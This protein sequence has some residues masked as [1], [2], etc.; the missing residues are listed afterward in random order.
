MSYRHPSSRVLSRISLEDRFN[1][2]V[3]LSGTSPEQLVPKGIFFLEILVLSS[4]TATIAD[5]KGTTI[6][7]GISS[8]TQENMPLRCDYGIT[9]TGA[10]LYAKG[11]VIEG[12][13]SE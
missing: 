1:N 3:I 13:L 2:Q 10:V 7:S 9:I 8:F 6:M 12:C 4:G 11:F 5:G